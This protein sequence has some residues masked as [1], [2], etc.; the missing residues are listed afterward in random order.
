MLFQLKFQGSPP[1]EPFHPKSKNLWKRKTLLDM[2]IYFKAVENQII[3][4]VDSIAR[5]DW[6][7]SL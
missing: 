4:W 3:F 7:N 5:M 1:S 6:S 2:K